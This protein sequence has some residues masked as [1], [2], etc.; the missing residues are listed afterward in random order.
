MNQAEG[1][2]VVAVDSQR[3][4]AEFIFYYAALSVQLLAHFFALIKWPNKTVVEISMLSYFK[5]DDLDFLIFSGPTVVILMSM[6]V[7]VRLYIG[8]QFTDKDESFQEEYIKQGE[9]FQQK[10]S[11]LRTMLVFSLF[12]T[13][14]FLY[15]DITPF[16]SLSIF[17][18]A[19]SLG[20]HTYLM[21]PL[22]KDDKESKT[23]E[24]WGYN[25]SIVVNDCILG[26]Y[27]FLIGSVVLSGSAWWS[28]VVSKF[29]LLA[30]GAT[31]LVFLFEYFLTYRESRRQSAKRMA[32]NYISGIKAGLDFP[33]SYRAC[34]YYD[35][36]PFS[37]VIYFEDFV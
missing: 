24:G 4:P 36:H 11:A 34:R 31:V 27:L 8:L 18:L 1:E 25:I 5:S 20:L 15:L 14:L 13:N 12:F 33:Y 26:V 19:I 22:M 30:I 16:F 28:K 21:S 2:K 10:E 17:S 32:R 35:Y 3:I 7:L 29:I 23:N 37:M 9:L 6:T